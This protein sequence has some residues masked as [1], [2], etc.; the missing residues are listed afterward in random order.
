VEP[1][2]SLRPPPFSGKPGAWPPRFGLP[3]PPP[4]VVAVFQPRSYQKTKKNFIFKQ[5]VKEER[6]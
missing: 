5:A 3:P 2:C 6:E 1:R 4:V